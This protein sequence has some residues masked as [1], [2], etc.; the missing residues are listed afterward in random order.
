M[1][2]IQ[3]GPGFFFALL[4]AMILAVAAIG[5]EAF[6][7][8]AP[9]G[10]ADLAE[11]L[12][13][14]V[15]NIS[16][17]QQVQGLGNLGPELQDLQRKFGQRKASSL[18]SGFII[19][20]S[21]IVV[22]NHHVIRDA[23]AIK[24][25]LSDGREFD[26]EVRGKDAETDLA[27]LQMKSNGVKFPAVKFGNSDNAR[28]GEWVVAIGNPFG[29]GGS[30][31]AGII[32][33][34]NRNIQSGIY[35]D[36]IQT[37]AAINRGNSGGP[38]FNMSGEVIGVNTAIFSQTGGS[39]GVGF[40][41]PSDLAQSVVSQLLNYGETRRGYLGVS[42]SEL[43]ITEAR[44]RGFDRPVGALVSQVTPQSPADLAGI[45]INDLIIAFDRRPIKNSRELTRA[46]AETSVGS[47][48]PV[49]LRRAGKEMTVSVRI[50]R[51]EV[52]LGSGGTVTGGLPEQTKKSG[53]FQS[54]GLVLQEPTPDVLRNYGLPADT[55]G[56]VVTAVDPNSDAAGIIQPGDVIL[57]IGWEKVVRAQS[58]VDRLRDLVSQNAGPVQV[59]I[60]RGD[61]LF[62]ETLRP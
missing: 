47:V 56:A 16:T 25:V 52:R 1:R 59:R 23:V 36:Y 45:Q 29:L 8:G 2:R 13:P 21:G 33:A 6:A 40:S 12:T 30:V 38:L 53:L 32:S 58:A 26:A 50:E 39:V 57:E 51:R 34:R 48:V 7:R 61:L 55:K 27:V 4:S 24:V 44:N 43:D 14:A 15:V 41:I 42:I 54:S 5:N 9:D 22:T 11:R 18:G 49:K 3:S 28:V 35:D 17:T 46:V 10:F 31:S 37:D 19:D 20:S 60:Q 62:Y